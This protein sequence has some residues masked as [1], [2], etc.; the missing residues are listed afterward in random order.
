M[1]ECGRLRKGVGF[2]W[3]CCLLVLVSAIFHKKRKPRHFFFNASFCYFYLW[4]LIA[5]QT[6]DLPSVGN[7]RNSDKMYETIDFEA[8]VLG[9]K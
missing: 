8:W 7:N 2:V 5:K 4:P 6:L 3:Y 1:E 9:H